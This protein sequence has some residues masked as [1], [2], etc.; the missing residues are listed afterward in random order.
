MHVSF[1][2]STSVS[3]F[4]SGFQAFGFSGSRAPSSGSLSVVSWV[5]AQVPSSASVLVG[6]AAGVDAVARAAFPAAHV[7]SVGRP[8]SR[9]AFAA[10]S[11]RC[12]AAVAAAGGLW[13]SF[14]SSGCPVGLVAF[15]FVLSLFLRR[16]VGFLGFACLCDRFRGALFGVVACR[17]FAAGGLGAGSPGVRLVLLGSFY[18]SAFSFL[19]VSSQYLCIISLVLL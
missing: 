16:W 15:I 8:A 18:R 12:V 3:L 19:G 4:L 10:R 7:F 1:E 9:G 13:L 2:V 6:C 11:V 14:P 5:C 17:G